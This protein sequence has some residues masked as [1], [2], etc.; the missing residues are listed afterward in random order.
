MLS[1]IEK[2]LEH[3][4]PFDLS[5][6][7]VLAIVKSYRYFGVYYYDDIY[8]VKGYGSWIGKTLNEGF[9]LFRSTSPDDAW[10]MVNLFRSVREY[11]KFNK[12]IKEVGIS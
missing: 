8:I 12:I 9:D 11:H 2:A 4:N 7:S 3:K 10:Y 5:V 6:D 1:S